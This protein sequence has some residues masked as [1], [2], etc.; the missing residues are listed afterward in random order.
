RVIRNGVD[1][2]PF[3]VTP[4]PARI[5]EELGLRP[6][7]PLVAVVS[8]LS[9]LKGLEHFLEA[10][11]VVAPKFPD[12]RFLVV[13][14][15]PPHD[16]GYLDELNAAAQRFGVEDPVIFPGLRSVLPALLRCVSVAVMPSPNEAPSN[17]LLESMAAGA[18]TVATR[19]GG[20]PEA[21]VDGETGLLVEPGDSRSLA[22]AIGKLL[23]DR[24]LAAG[25]GHAARARIAECYSVR[26]MVRAT[27]DVYLDLLERKQ[28]RR[29]PSAAC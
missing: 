11:A 12:A 26:R 8:R 20:T 23:T 16:L 9:R 6:S 10:A 21:L 1:L 25:L 4:E 27:E 13:G 7:T 19:V 2:G 29:L 15:A 28:R 17:P 14:E 22:D 3:N 18:P 24:T 5:R